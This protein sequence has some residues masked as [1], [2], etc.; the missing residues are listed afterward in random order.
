M[1]SQKSIQSIS[2]QTTYSLVEAIKAKDG[3]TNGHSKRVADYSVMI[4]ERSGKS[5]E[6]CEEIRIIA[7]LH[8]IGKIGIAD[9]IIKKADKL[10]DEEFDVIKTHPVKGGE[11]LSKIKLSPNLAIGAK[12]H[13]ERY[14]GTGYP[15]KLKGEEIPE[16]ARIIAVAD[17]YDA[18]ASK[19]SYRD[20]LPQYVIR[21]E[22]QNGIG[23]QFDPKFAK[24]MIDII[25][26]DVDYKLRE[27]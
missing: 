11:M 22:F 18:M 27:K 6:E 23:T 2:N 13:H 15:N 5:K 8:D 24:I 3:Y 4:A 16:V 20:V 25:D 12:W 26:E 21:S 1:E 14:D 9:S 19:R 7:L 17:S 10:T